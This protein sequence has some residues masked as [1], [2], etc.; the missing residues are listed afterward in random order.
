MPY[1]WNKIVLY[2]R[3]YISTQFYMSLVR[4]RTWNAAWRQCYPLWRIR[5]TPIEW[6]YRYGVR[7]SDSGEQTPILKYGS[8]K[9]QVK[10]QVRVMDDPPWRV[11]GPNRCRPCYL[12]PQLCQR[13]ENSFCTNKASLQ[14]FCFEYVDSMSMFLV[15]IHHWIQDVSF[16]SRGDEMYT[17]A[18]NIWT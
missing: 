16:L 7:E 10:T 18:A 1:Q 13:S 4:W 6:G 17:T 2:Y 11:G 14:E 8:E 15:E 12:T 5:G 9:S 3:L